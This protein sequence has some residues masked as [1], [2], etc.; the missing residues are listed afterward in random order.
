MK[1]YAKK[2]TVWLAAV[3]AVTFLTIGGCGAKENVPV[4][5]EAT[6]TAEPASTQQA[7]PTKAPV[8][9]TTATPAA[10]PTKTSAPTDAPVAEPTKASNPTEIP[11]PTEKPTP[12]YTPTPTPRLERS[13]V[14][15]ENYDIDVFSLPVWNVTEHI[16]H[17]SVEKLDGK[18][19]IFTAAGP[20]GNPVRFW[21][22][23][24][25]IKDEGILF[26]TDGRI[27]SLDAV[28]RIYSIAPGVAKN[29][30]PSNWLSWWEA[31]NVDMDPH[32][33][34]PDRFVYSTQYS[35]DAD[36]CSRRVFDNR[37][38]GFSDYQGNFFGVGTFTP[39]APDGT[40]SFI[41]DILIDK[42]Y[43]TYEEDDKLT[44]FDRFTLAGDFYGVY[45]ENEPYDRGR[46]IYDE[47]KGVLSFY[48]LGLPKLKHELIPY[49][50]EE[51]R[52]AAN[53][54]LSFI[55]AAEGGMWEVTGVKG[56]DGTIV[57]ND[58]AVM[59]AGSDIMIKL[60]DRTYEVMV[61]VLP[62]YHG[63]STM[64]DLVP[65]AFPEA[66]GELKTLVIPIAWPDEPQNATDEVLDRFRGE[67]GRVADFSGNVKDYSDKG[68]K[69]RFSLS[70]YFD[71]AS[72]GKMQVVS[73]LTDWYRSPYDFSEWRYQNVDPE[74][75]KTVLD[76]LYKT[77]PDVDFS[78]FDR[79]NNGY[80]DSV[81]FLNAGSPN[82][83]GFDI[84]SFE[85]AILYR[86]TYTMTF[87]GTHER[88]G[89]NCAVNMNASH[90]T[91][92]TLLHEFS[93][94]FGL[95]DYY[96]V[97]YSGATPLGGYDMQ[98][99]SKGDWNAYSKYA[100]GW[101]TPTVVK[102][103]KE[104]EHVDIEIGAMSA[105]GDA[106]VVPIAGADFDVPFDEYMLVDLF[107]DCGVNKYDAEE[108]GLSGVTGVRIYHV[109]AR[110]ER[111]DYADRGY[112]F[113]PTPIGT[114]HIA[115]DYSKNGFYN[116]ELIEAG[117]VNRFTDLFLVN[118]PEK[119][120]FRKY[121]VDKDDFF[122]A[123]D[124]FT[125]SSYGSFF[126]NG[127]MDLGCDLGYSI[128][129]LSITGK[130]ADAKAVIRVTRE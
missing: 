39:Y 92:N 85:G 86:S 56:P 115:N 12:T 108:F 69:N 116:I 98:D 26:H 35:R 118:D 37:D 36:G 106:V 40:C 73:Y 30:D 100:V 81:V 17:S 3:I 9:E 58:K 16:D 88:P 38:W 46:E 60:G 76:W 53:D 97:T 55:Y 22:H 7:V 19:I 82:E 27:Q 84:I 75:F 23:D 78:S 70:A 110:M 54:A 126:Y 77:Y 20:D 21:G 29:D 129:V 113:D 25:E 119:G 90:F 18:D 80:F 91:D 125:L 107:S 71:E 66:K 94:M 41:G 114:I 43:V 103:L 13:I 6:S 123:G 67:L 8:E 121:A 14:P 74:F 130:G 61:D 49:K 99:S 59:T 33:T 79:D 2:K 15:Y 122:K 65:Y 63:A 124:R 50:D 89:I 95:I 51:I 128:E 62:Q 72:Y 104:G 105:T 10:E 83:M 117:G 87:A 57:E 127:L 24:V 93:H 4:S 96:D 64:H 109:D 120:I 31:F 44:E 48:L 52:S 68:P 5:P 102:D 11:T 45:M 42:I 101:I 112:N 1:H 111:R 28:G 34:S 47:R 32:P